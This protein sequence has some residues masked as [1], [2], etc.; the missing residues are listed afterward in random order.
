MSEW[1]SVEEL[2]PCPFCGGKAKLREIKRELPFSEEINEFG[3]TCEICGCSPFWFG[4][5]DLYYKADWKDIR[6]KLQDKA[7]E[8]WNRRASD[9]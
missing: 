1:I 7:I 4:K 5:V 9:V 8:E 2:K 3:V 6:N